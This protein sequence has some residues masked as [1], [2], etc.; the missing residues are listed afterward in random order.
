MQKTSS[1]HAVR[2]HKAA[3]S[4]TYVCTVQTFRCSTC[5]KNCLLKHRLLFQ[6][7]AGLDSLR[8]MC[9]D[10]GVPKVPYFHFLKGKAGVVAEFTANLT[11]EKLQH[12]R[13]QVHFH[14]A[15]QC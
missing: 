6:V 12:L 8:D 9:T 15:K 1:V 7:N 10:I 3:W 4:K 14:G 11:A 5:C 13:S 2:R